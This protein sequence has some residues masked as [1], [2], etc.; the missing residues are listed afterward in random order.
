MKPASVIFLGVALLLVLTGFILTCVASSQAKKQGISLYTTVTQPGE[1]ENVQTYSFTDTTI[2]RLILSFNHA[3]V[4]ICQSTDDT[5]RIDLVNFKTGTFDITQTN[6]MLQI[7]NRSQFFAFFD[8]V[9]EGNFSFHGLR[10][11]L[12]YSKVSSDEQVVR[13]YLPTQ[14]RVKVISCETEDGS[15]SLRDFVCS[16]DLRLLAVADR[17][18]LENVKTS[19][20]IALTLRD[21]AKAEMKTV[22]C[23]SSTFQCDGATVAAGAFT[24]GDL[25]IK[26]SKAALNL[27][28]TGQ[29]EE[30]WLDLSTGNGMF[31]VQGE[32]KAS[33]YSDLPDYYKEMLRQREQAEQQT[34][35]PVTDTP[36]NVQDITT[37]NGETPEVR[38][39]IS[40]NLQA[41]SA[42]I[43]FENV[44]A[45]SQPSEPNA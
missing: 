29:R 11:Y 9:K 45:D 14:S 39:V 34:Q 24:T 31:I 21:G 3:D 13:V 30:Y 17:V 6:R 5:S 15:I 19:S 35:S 16:C 22:S 8:N 33:P 20:Q 42:D 10:D 7:T 27:G 26:G 36:Q 23:N 1:T 41:G 43:H 25:T 38:K 40:V 28:L 2:D 44:T 37:E 4:E 18:S 32:E 12:A